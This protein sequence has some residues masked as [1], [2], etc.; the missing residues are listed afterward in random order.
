MELITNY[1]RD[2]TYRHMLNDLTQKVFGFDFESWVTNGY[3]EGDYIPFSLMEDGKFVANVS[4]NRMAFIQNGSVRNYI[5][6]G[7]VMTDPEYRKQG[8]AS[9]LMKRV[10]EEYEQDCDGIYLFGDLSAIGFYQKMNFRIENQYRYFIKD[11]YCQFKKEE[12]LF[13]PVKDM[14]DKIKPKHISILFRIAFSIFIV[15]I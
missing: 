3:F 4:A 5:Q 9:K 12:N 15:F 2:D 11:E 8:L 14:D 10:I 13:K 1:M 7:T 6:I